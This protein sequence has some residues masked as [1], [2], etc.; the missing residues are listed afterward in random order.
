MNLLRPVVTVH[1]YCLEFT[2]A[3]LPPYASV[4][5]GGTLGKS[6]L[7]GI[8]LHSVQFLLSHSQEKQKCM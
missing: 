3:T 1:T 6:N 7:A 2:I 4:A 8:S 5:F